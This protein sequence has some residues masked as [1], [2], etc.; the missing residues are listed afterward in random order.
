MSVAEVQPADYPPNTMCVCG[1]LI[2]PDQPFVEIEADGGLFHWNA[3]G[4]HR[5]DAEL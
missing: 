1:E 2:H 3:D 4:G 5:T